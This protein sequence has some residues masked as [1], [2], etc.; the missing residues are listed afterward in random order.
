MIL[1]AALVTEIKEIKEKR[2]KEDDV[3]LYVASGSRHSIIP[4][5][6]FEFSDAEIHEDVYKIIKYSCEEV[7]ST[8]EQLNKVMKLWTTF[9]EPMLG[10]H[11]RPHG[12][13]A[14]EDD[15]VSKHQ[16][17][18]NTMTSTMESEDSPNV[19]ATTASLKKPKSNCS[20]DFTASPQRVNFSRVGFKNVD[21][22]VKEGLAVTCGERLSNVDIAFTSGSDA[23]HGMHLGETKKVQ[24]IN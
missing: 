1:M 4:D 8:K 24:V 12:S 3:L 13:L 20:S 7:C 2:Q 14:T 11:S 5:L 6:E 23:N 15:D 22:M 21:A 9:L 18:K 16:I 17:V 19:D 10:V